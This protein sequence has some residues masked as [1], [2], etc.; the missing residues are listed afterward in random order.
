MARGARPT[1]AVLVGRSNPTRKEASVALQGLFVA[2]DGFACRATFDKATDRVPVEYHTRTPCR[3]KG[4][5]YPISSNQELAR[6]VNMCPV[7]RATW[8][9]DRTDG[10]PF[11]GNLMPRMTEKVVRRMLG[12][13]ARAENRRAR[14]GEK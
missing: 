9:R 6:V 14:G 12:V 4:V 7:K 1:R 11:A 2:D 8:A 13:T 5:F 3:G 10:I